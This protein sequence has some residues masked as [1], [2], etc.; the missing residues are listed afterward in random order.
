M[1][2]SKQGTIKTLSVSPSLIVPACILSTCIIFD[3]ALV[4][5]LHLHAQEMLH[6][7]GFIYQTA[8]SVHD[9][10]ISCIKHLIFKYI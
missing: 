6:Q 9:L 5:F 1:V 2:Y 8:V 7:N 10:L 4:I 3:K